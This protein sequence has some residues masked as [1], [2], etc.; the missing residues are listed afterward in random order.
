MGCKK[1]N[2]N[3]PFQI[4]SILLKGGEVSDN[5]RTLLLN[6]YMKMKIFLL[7]LAL[8]LCLPLH[9][10]SEEPLE[11]T[12]VEAVQRALEKDEAT[13]LAEQEHH[14][15]LLALYYVRRA[16]HWKISPSFQ[17]GMIGGG[18]L[19][20]RK[21][22][23]GGKIKVQHNLPY[24]VT[25]STNPELIHQAK[26]YFA[27]VKSE[28]E[29]PLGIGSGRYMYRKDQDEAIFEAEKKLYALEK[30]KQKTTLHAI[31]AFLDCYREDALFALLQEEEK[32]EKAE[33]KRM[34]Q[35]QE[36]AA[37]L[38]IS[39][40]FH[41]RHLEEEAPL[42]SIPYSLVEAQR[43][44]LQNRQ[45]LL[46]NQLIRKNAQRELALSRNR[47][48]PDVKVVLNYSACGCDQYLT[49]SCTLQKES[50]WGIGIKGET[51]ANCQKDR[52]A[53][54]KSHGKLLRAVEKWETLRDQIN[55][56]VEKAYLH[57]QRAEKA[58]EEAQE[59]LKQAEGALCILLLKFDHG[60]ATQA[61]RM[62]AFKAAKERK[63]ST[64]CASVERQK[65][66]YAWLDAIGLLN[67]TTI[68]CPQ[69]YEDSFSS[70]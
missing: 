51:S 50:T 25:L 26:E 19:G 24:G 53:Y 44:A 46:E 20:N 38:K 47:L 14:E 8:S 41:L 29:I 42:P 55:R 21:A 61:E 49:K 64:I 11:L 28:L 65:Q 16:Q 70:S 63:I 66:W 68:Q 9:A 67:L 32:R 36:L 52:L 10:A 15:A 56:E 39:P 45:E 13:H 7:F 54:Y 12:L 37:L 40:S 3:L 60:L 34:D 33:E 4:R 57:Y 6:N 59:K 31:R 48:F 27:N 2:F 18:K 5:K 58:D 22:S 69:L 43:V 30:T 1:K 62:H 17:A 23:Y 35:Q